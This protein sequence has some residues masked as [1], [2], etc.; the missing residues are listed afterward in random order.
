MSWNNIKSNSC[1]GDCDWEETRDEVDEL[2]NDPDFSFA[3]DFLSQLDDW[4]EKHKHVTESQKQ[5]IQNI[6]DGAANR[7]QNGDGYE[8]D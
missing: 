8:L 6:I 2:L 5:A 7:G 1:D 4:I 3:W